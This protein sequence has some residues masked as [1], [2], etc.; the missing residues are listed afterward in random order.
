MRGV[1]HEAVVSHREWAATKQTSLR[2][3]KKIPLLCSEQAVQSHDIGR[4]YEI[5]TLGSR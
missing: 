1:A 2:G 4:H 5:A 3:A